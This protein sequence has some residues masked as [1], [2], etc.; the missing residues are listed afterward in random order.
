MINNLEKVGLFEEV[1]DQLNQNALNL[2]GGQQ[3]RLCIARALSLNPKALLM[4]EPTSSLDPFST[5]IIENLI[6]NLKTTY[7]II[8]V[9]HN[10]A[11]AKRLADHLAIFW[12]L[13]NI[14]ICLES[15]TRDQIIHHSTDPRTRSYLQGILG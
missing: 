14:G 6:K 15:G 10:I 11:Q 1:K 2:S 12:T 5:D 13:D 7:P 4:D 8:L 3:Q 9:T